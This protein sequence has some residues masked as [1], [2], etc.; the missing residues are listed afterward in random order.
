MC[1]ATGT[2]FLL[3]WSAAEMRTN[4]V[5]GSMCLKYKYSDE[6]TINTECSR[7]VPDLGGGVVVDESLALPPTHTTMNPHTPHTHKHTRDIYLDQ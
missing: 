2:V 3:F 6:F 5:E 1:V 4:K 7:A